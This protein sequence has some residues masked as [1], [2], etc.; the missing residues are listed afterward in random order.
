LWD[1]LVDTWDTAVENVSAVVDTVI[2]TFDDVWDTVVGYVSPVV[3][4]IINTFDDVWDTTVEQV[5]EVIDTVIETVTSAG[6]TVYDSVSNVYNTVTNYISNIYNTVNNYI[7]NTYNTVTNNISNTY[8]TLTTA[9]TQ[10]IGLTIENVNEWWTAR[11]AWVERLVDTRF[12]LIAPTFNAMGAIING[13][14][15]FFTDPEDW[16][17]K[18]FDK[19]IERF[20]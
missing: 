20:W 1:W 18:R 17:Y 15:E 8:Q 11:A 10:V 16:L 6:S 2:N 9:I 3:D 19:I 7:T 13:F 14:N 5:P 4:T 12:A